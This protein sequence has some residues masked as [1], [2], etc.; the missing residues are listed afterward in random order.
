MAWIYLIIA[1]LLEIGWP[2]GLK[3]SQEGENRWLGI[4]IAV[5]F[6]VASGFMLWL[7]QRDISMGTSYAVWTGIGAAGTFLVGILF[8]NDAATFG[9]IAGVLMIISGVI[10]LKISH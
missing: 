8:Y 6:M 10:T 4:A 1:G 5:A 2:V 3:M 9:R 7:A